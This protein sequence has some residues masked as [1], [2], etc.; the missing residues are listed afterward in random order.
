M[1]GFGWACRLKKSTFHLLPNA[2][3]VG[4]LQGESNEQQ[5]KHEAHEYFGNNLSF[6][7]VHEI[8]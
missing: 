8:A 6:C 5:H 7:F 1:G 3:F 4:Y 2:K